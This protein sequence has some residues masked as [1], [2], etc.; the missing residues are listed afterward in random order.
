VLGL[1]FAKRRF[2][3][4]FRPV[5]ISIFPGII[6]SIPIFIVWK[7]F[8]L[9][10]VYRIFYSSP[11]ITAM[12]TLKEHIS[13]LWE[14]MGPVPYGYIPSLFAVIGLILLLFQKPK[15]LGHYL[16][17]AWLLPMCLLAKL[18]LLGIYSPLV[19]HRLL[20]YG[21]VPL[22]IT[23]AIGVIEIIAWGSRLVGSLG[24]FAVRK[25]A[26]FGIIGLI[27]IS[28][29]F[30]AATTIMQAPGA[31]PVITKAGEEAMLWLKENTP[32]DSVI[33]AT[34]Y[35]PFATGGYIAGIAGR[36]Y[37]AARS[38]QLIAGPYLEYQRNLEALEVISLRNPKLVSAILDKY[39]QTYSKGYLFVANKPTLWYSPRR[40][41]I[42]L[43]KL[44]S[45]Y[46]SVFENSEIII[47]ELY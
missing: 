26:I 7:G 18:D 39:A 11:N 31:R 37:I 6:F 19:P 22:S 10:R 47:F 4:A 24:H 1:L 2:I 28:Q 42:P 29:V 43:E 32:E 40:E 30:E 15:V 16:I 25:A 21:M 14:I 23:A 17:F 44:K 33:F 34:I 13:H 3:A 36:A 27:I 12:T 9:E 45:Y 41:A 20:A 35:A 5:F 38:E 8:Y 46:R